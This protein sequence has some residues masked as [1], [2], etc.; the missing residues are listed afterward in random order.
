MPHTHGDP[1]ARLCRPARWPRGFAPQRRWLAA[2]RTRPG[3]GGNAL[4]RNGTARARGRRRVRLVEAPH[5][6]HTSLRSQSPSRAP[7]PAA[8]LTPCYPG[9]LIF[10]GSLLRKYLQFFGVDLSKHWKYSY[11]NIAIL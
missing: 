1:H 8:F 2:R 11:E 7:E 9:A 10:N 4:L 5:I 6:P 3:L